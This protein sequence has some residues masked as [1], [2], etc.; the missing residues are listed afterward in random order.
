VSGLDPQSTIDVSGVSKYSDQAFLRGIFVSAP[1]NTTIPMT[2]MWEKITNQLGN[3]F[4]LTTGGTSSFITL[5]YR[6]K[7]LTRVPR[8][9][10]TVHP[11]EEAQYG[12]E[13][14]RRIEA[15]V[16]GKEGELETFGKVPGMPG[17]TREIETGEA[18]IKGAQRMFK[19][20]GQ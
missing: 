5:K 9:F 20:R 7:V 6:V 13:R 19:G 1:T 18:I 3:I 15:A 12:Q 14:A 10:V 2:E 16:L 4:M 8:P 17:T 11:S